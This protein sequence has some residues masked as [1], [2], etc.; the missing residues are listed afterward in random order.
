MSWTCK[1]CTVIFAE[2]ADF[3]RH[4]TDCIKRGS[5]CG[6]C[7]DAF[8]PAGLT[9]HLDKSV[10]GLRSY[11]VKDLYMW[12]KDVNDQRVMVLVKEYHRNILNAVANGRF[13]THLNF[14]CADNNPD[15]R[16]RIL[17]RVIEELKCLFVDVEIKPDDAGKRI[18]VSWSKTAFC[19]SIMKEMQ[20]DNSAQEKN[21]VVTKDDDEE[22]VRF[23]NSVY[24]DTSPEKRD[25]PPA[26]IGLKGR[27]EVSKLSV[28]KM[29]DFYTPATLTE[30]DCD[31]G[32]AVNKSALEGVAA[33][34]TRMR[35]I[36]SKYPSKKIKSSINNWDDVVPEYDWATAVK[37]SASEETKRSIWEKHI[38]SKLPASDDEQE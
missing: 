20:R 1:C 22:W 37:K 14:V 2:R 25:E 23:W 18:D 31:T 5:V 7:L 32:T 17:A 19:I 15:V 21:A 9:A 24:N 33:H 38:G 8:T 16:Q 27:A 6:K 3:D 10:C 4:R 34:K 36:R 26:P 35:E 30:N 12:A 28:R 13:R 11:N 29:G